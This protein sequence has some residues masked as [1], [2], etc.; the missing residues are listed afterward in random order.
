MR[1]EIEVAPGELFDKLTILEIKLKKI[2]DKDKLAHI[3]KEGDLL[4]ASSNRLCGR[5]VGLDVAKLRKFID[6]LREIN[7][8]IWDIE[9]AVREYEQNQD[10][11]DGFVQ[12]ARS[13]YITNDKRATIKKEINTLLNSDIMEEKSYTEYQKHKI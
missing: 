4:T 12:A 3:Q 1:I 6:Q 11:G 5:L 13:V 8:Q 9:D 10:F 2:T 7:E